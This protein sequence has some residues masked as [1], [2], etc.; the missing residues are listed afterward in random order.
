M[1]Q[2]A[3]RNRSS[4]LVLLAVLVAGCAT[5]GPTLSETTVPPPACSGADHRPRLDFDGLPSS[6][7]RH[8][9]RLVD[10]AANCD[11][12]Q[13]DRI[14][15]QDGLV[16]TF[17]G[18]VVAPGDWPELEHD[19]LPV[20]RA[21][22]DVFTLPA[23]RIDGDLTWPSAVQWSRLE[24]GSAQDQQAIED[25]GGESGLYS[26]SPDGQYLGWRTT[27][28]GDGRWTQFSLGPVAELRAG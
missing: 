13:L 16:A 14:A 26:W 27:I 4:A 28:T 11:Y 7:T 24:D 9:G 25:V 23:A 22:I 6:V 10:A 1:A 18:D 12:E 21:L 5:E 19:G 2:R 8:R 3:V 17:D 15:R 20:M